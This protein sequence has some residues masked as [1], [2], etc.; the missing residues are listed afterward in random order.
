MGL[1]LFVEPNQTATDLESRRLP[2]QAPGRAENALRNS[3]RCCGHNACAQSMAK[4]FCE[5]LVV[6]TWVMRRYDPW[7]SL[8]E[9]IATSLGHDRFSYWGAW[10]P[11]GPGR[12]GVC[13]LVVRSNYPWT[14]FSH[15]NIASLCKPYHPD[16]IFDL[17]RCSAQRMSCCLRNLRVPLYE[18]ELALLQP[19]SFPVGHD[20]LH[21][22]LNG[23]FRVF[24][25]VW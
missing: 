4:R 3:C 8:Q 5:H 21:V 25:I 16:S 2:R 1:L 20:N 17:E 13:K 9:I 19:R 22:F 18:I 7:S 24:D 14:A 6:V 23:E 12:G 10:T 11:L 15:Q